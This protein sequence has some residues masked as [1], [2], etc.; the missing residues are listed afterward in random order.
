MADEFYDYFEGTLMF[1]AQAALGGNALPS[2]P[3]Y[4]V[5]MMNSSFYHLHNRKFGSFIT[6]ETG[7]E[8]YPFDSTRPSFVDFWRRFSI[9]VVSKDYAH[10]TVSVLV[11]FLCDLTLPRITLLPTAP[12]IVDKGDIPWYGEDSYLPVSATESSVELSMQITNLNT[13]L[14]GY[15]TYNITVNILKCDDDNWTICEVDSKR[16]MGSVPSTVGVHPLQTCTASTLQPVVNTRHDR[17]ITSRASSFSIL[18]VTLSEDVEDDFTR[19]NGAAQSGSPTIS[20]T[21][22]FFGPN[23]QCHMNPLLIFISPD[24]VLVEDTKT[25]VQF[26]VINQDSVACESREL[27]MLATSNLTTVTVRKRSGV[28]GTFPT[29]MLVNE[30]SVAAEHLA[31]ST[32][33]IPVTISVISDDSVIRRDILV[34]L[35]RRFPSVSALTESPSDGPI[36]IV[37][38][39]TKII[40]LSIQNKDVNCEENT[41]SLALLACKDGSGDSPDCFPMR[42]YPEDGNGHPPYCVSR[43]WG[44]LRACLTRP[45]ISIRAG[46]RSSVAI[47]LGAPLETA[48]NMT[49]D[50]TVVSTNMRDGSSEKLAFE[51]TAQPREEC[52]FNTPYVTVGCSAPHNQVD[53]NA[54]LGKKGRLLSCMAIIRN[55]DS[56]SCGRDVF[57]LSTAYFPAGFTG[58]FD[59]GSGTATT[60][61]KVKVYPGWKEEVKFTLEYPA[62]VSEERPALP[63][64]VSSVHFPELGNFDIDLSFG[65][66]NY[67]PPSLSVKTVNPTLPLDDEDRPIAYSFINE[68]KVVR[69]VITNNYNSFCNNGNPSA[70]RLNVEIE[71]GSPS[72]KDLYISSSPVAV[73]KAG[74]AAGVLWAFVGLQPGINATFSVEAC[75]VSNSTM[76]SEKQWMRRVVN[77]SCALQQ[78]IVEFI[79]FSRGSYRSNS[80]SDNSPHLHLAMY[81]HGIDRSAPNSESFTL[82]VRIADVGVLCPEYSFRATI[83]PTYENPNKEYFPANKKTAGPMEWRQTCSP[84]LISLSAATGR[85]RGNFTCTIVA[86]EMIL[87]S[88]YTFLLAVDDTAGNIV[89]RTNLDVTAEFPCAAPGEPMGLT[90]EQLNTATSFSP[91]IRLQWAL[92]PQR[93]PCCEPCMTYVYRG[94]YGSTS[95]GNCSGDASTLDTSCRELSRRGGLDDIHWQLLGEVH[96]DKVSFEYSSN[97]KEGDQYAYR[98]VSCDGYNRCST[99]MM[100]SGL[101][102][103]IQD[104]LESYFLYILSATILTL[105]FF[106][107]RLVY[108]NFYDPLDSY[109]YHGPSSLF[110]AA[111]EME[112]V[113]LIETS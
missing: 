79:D 46:G 62:K 112:E 111:D 29:H 6:S 42:T 61:Q 11:S 107:A 104:S 55:H 80:S 82:H 51:A 31:T 40:L 24:S 28:L 13:P 68:T 71:K 4:L 50:F 84:D 30:L 9:T 21:N 7:V 27:V 8:S 85:S 94:N 39:E 73:I 90:V 49:F 19:R 58:S 26:Y 89:H 110:Q 12:G 100:C 33:E 60:S 54:S 38:G 34:P 36:T 20:A 52:V 113:P 43:S 72:N 87:P 93:L 56:Y 86:R 65:Y 81:S 57:T 64:R 103:V 47:V 108:L 97:L 25:V 15:S 63:V 16:R 101:I 59:D 22:Y 96:Y 41:Y 10:N 3:T 102:T 1:H 35:C 23:R 18:R 67:E 53:Q 14:C 106:V 44:S 105:S 83:E 45:L 92:P 37:S 69:L 70:F 99:H 48:Q 75:D 95:S 74:S 109:P 76:C 17:N 77:A 98:V 66:C 91:T 5:G 88:N 2:R 32:T 78:P